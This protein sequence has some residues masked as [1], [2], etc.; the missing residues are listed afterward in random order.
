MIPILWISAALFTHSWSF[1]IDFLFSRIF[2]T[3]KITSVS[4]ILNKLNTPL[5]SF[6]SNIILKALMISLLDN[7]FPWVLV[8][9]E[10]ESPNQGVSSVSFRITENTGIFLCSSDLPINLRSI[11][12]AL[13]LSF[14]YFCK[15][16]LAI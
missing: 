10:S 9:F 1:K 11:L 7:W 14:G 15:N 8:R 6:H 4:L 16:V 3:P 2:S 5:N 13:S 12:S